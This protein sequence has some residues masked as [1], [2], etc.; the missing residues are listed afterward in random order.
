MKIRKATEKDI[1]RIDKICEDG[2]YQEHSLQN[3]GDKK[4]ISEG[5]ESDLK[6]HRRTIR[7]NLEDKKQYWIVIE[8]KGVIVGVGSAYIKKDKG[9]TE[10]VYIAKESQRKGYGKKILKHLVS[11]LELKKVEHIESNL[12]VKNI[13]SLRL[14]KKL[15]FK[16]YVLRVRLR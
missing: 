16:P 2:I 3:P 15:G 4:K 9:V 6:F 7:K 10:S 13:P 5:A 14:H 1:P 12:L 11:W 8:N